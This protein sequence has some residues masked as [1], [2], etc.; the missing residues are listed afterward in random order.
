MRSRHLRRRRNIF[1]ASACN[2]T[3]RRAAPWIRRSAWL[4]SRRTPALPAPATAASAHRL[5][6]YSYRPPHPARTGEA[7]PDSAFK[8]APDTGFIHV[9]AAPEENNSIPPATLLRAY[10]QELIR[11][12]LEYKDYYFPFSIA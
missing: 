2:V 7:Y 10:R 6:L 11:G 3:P 12:H 1:V 8:A 5:A 4:S 9:N